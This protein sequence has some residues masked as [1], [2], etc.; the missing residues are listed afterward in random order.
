MSSA[1]RNSFASFFAIWMPLLWLIK[2]EN[3]NREKKGKGKKRT[4]TTQK[5]VYLG[6][7]E[8][9]RGGIILQPKIVI[10]S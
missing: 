2:K 3:F 6:F 8:L 7:C 5:H 4:D 9:L 10:V 1:N